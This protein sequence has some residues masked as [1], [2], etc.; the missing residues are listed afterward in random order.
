MP[1]YGRIQVENAAKLVDCLKIVPIAMVM[2]SI[3][4]M[5]CLFYPIVLIAIFSGT[6]KINTCRVYTFIVDFQLCAVHWFSAE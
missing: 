6:N 3:S 1:V 5:K 4:V 2:A